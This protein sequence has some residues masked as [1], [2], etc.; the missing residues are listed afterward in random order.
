MYLFG[1]YCN[2]RVEAGLKCIFSFR[3]AFFTLR[4]ILANDGPVVTDGRLEV[5]VGERRVAVFE[6]V[7]ERSH[8]S[9]M[10]EH[11]VRNRCT[12]I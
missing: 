7:L 10:T 1:L 12:S 3:F 11:V 5:V 4:V 6:G 8:R 9:H 2:L